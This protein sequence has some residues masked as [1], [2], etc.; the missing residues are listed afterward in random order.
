[1]IRWFRTKAR[2]ELGEVT[3][4]QRTALLGNCRDIGASIENPRSLRA[5][6]LRKEDDVGLRPRAVWSKRAARTS[7]HCVQVGVFCQY[8]KNVSRLIGEQDIVRN[9]YCGA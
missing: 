4:G 9:N 7:Q 8:L 5:T 2:F 3:C 1:M 6:S